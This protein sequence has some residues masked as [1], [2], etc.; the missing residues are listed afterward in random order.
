[1]KIVVLDGYATNP[2]DLSWNGLAEFGELVV[3]DRTPAELTLDRAADAEI[4]ISNKV[5]LGAVEMAALPELRYIGLQATGFNIIDLE[6]ARSRGVVVC[7]VPAYS[8]SSVAQHA[9]ALLLELTRAVGLHAELVRQGVWTNCPDFAFRETP[10]VELS[11]KVFGII[12]YGDIGR[13]VAQIAVAFGMRVLVNTRTP[14]PTA[15]PEVSFVGVDQLLAESDVVS[16]H[17]PL[18]PETELLI[19]AER[20]VLMK[21]S[22]YLI[23]TGR[24]LLIDEAALATALHNGEIAGAGLDVLSQEPPPADNPLLNAPNCYVTPHLAWATLAARQRL[25]DTV[26]SNVRAFLSGTPQ[27]KVN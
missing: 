12:G 22:A 6:A 8:T 13:A 23:N 16:L 19:D 7:N 1:M 21:K 27:N 24:G 4:L 3:Y 20:L 18:T 14:D 11:D 26:V 9:F 17:C 10:Q 25:I 15:C 2:G 5:S